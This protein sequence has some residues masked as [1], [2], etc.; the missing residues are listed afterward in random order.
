MYRASDER[1]HAE[2]L[3]DLDAAADRLELGSQARTRAADVFL[4]SVPESERSK[5]ARLAAALYVGT[6]AAGDQR[7]QSEVAEAVGVSRLSVQSHWKGMLD[8]AGL[9]AP[10]W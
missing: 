7:S 10:D 9:D 5:R 3:A 6:L 4:S 2:W 1:E 8:A